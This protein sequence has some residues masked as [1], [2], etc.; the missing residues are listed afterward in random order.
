MVGN[1]G[2]LVEK[3]GFIDLYIERKEL[4]FSHSSS[5]NRGWKG[6]ILFVLIYT[7][8]YDRKWTQ[9]RRQ[10]THNKNTFDKW[11]EE[12]LQ[13]QINIQVDRVVTLGPKAQI[14]S[15]HSIEKS[16]VRPKLTY[17][18]MSS[19]C[20]GERWYYRHKIWRGN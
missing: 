5:Y 18:R 7:R 14:L 15:V 9:R 1:F 11:Q 4:F 13:R 16:N 8:V 3:D 6:I 17:V 12:Q 20:S 2:G 10:N 19:Y